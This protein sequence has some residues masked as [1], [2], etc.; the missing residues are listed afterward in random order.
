MAAL[1]ALLLGVAAA[2]AATAAAG[3]MC[4]DDCSL[5]G[6]CQPDGTCACDE[7]W[8]GD[9]CGV[10]DVLPAQPGSLYGYYGSPNVSSWGGNAVRDDGGTYHLYVAEMASGGLGG[11]GSQSECTHAVAAV[12][13]IRIPGGTPG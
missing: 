10:I 7:P 1:V 6:V 11:W 5:N 13:S 8:S 2:A 4:P 3:A 9:S 12:L